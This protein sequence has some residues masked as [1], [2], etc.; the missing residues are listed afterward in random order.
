MKSALLL[1]SFLSILQAAEPVE[2]IPSMQQALKLKS[3]QRFTD[4]EEESKKIVDTN[5]FDPSFLL[6]VDDDY[7]F[8]DPLSDPETAKEMA[9]HPPSKVSADILGVPADSALTPEG[10][11]K[12]ETTEVPADILG[13]PSDTDS[14]P[15]APVVLK[16]PKALAEALKKAPTKARAAT[17]KRAPVRPA[18]ET[19]ILTRLPALEKAEQAAAKTAPPA[20]AP[21]VPAVA[22]V[23]AA[24]IQ[25]PTPSEATPQPPVSPPATL[26]AQARPKVRPRM[27]V[28]S[29]ASEAPNL[30]PVLAGVNPFGVAT[31]KTPVPAS[32]PS[33]PLPGVSDI[34]ILLS[35]NQF[36]PSRVRM[37]EGIKTRLIFATIN[38]K[39]AALIIEKLQ[40]QRW[41]A[42]EEKLEITREISSS[43]VTEVL[44]SPAKGEYTFYDALSG[45]SGE[46]V[47]E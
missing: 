39:P 35:N 30:A 5:S 32:T 26:Q 37:K 38:K 42:K 1:L 36:Y 9:K 3:T 2:K 10:Q 33:E 31:Q 27:H 43:K 47:V 18:P 24:P 14:A 15:G 25:T 11:Q 13:L 23:P 7:S 4:P 44:L 22:Q 16:G 17:N 12:T 34:A 8:K 20:P 28:R 21:A 41:I 46:I 29:P 6:E 45:A 19:S 40:V